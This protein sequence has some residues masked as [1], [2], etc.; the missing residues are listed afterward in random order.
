VGGL[1]V[2]VSRGLGSVDLPL[3]MYAPA[4]VTL[5]SIG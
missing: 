1:P 4:E 5:F 3:R 2:Y